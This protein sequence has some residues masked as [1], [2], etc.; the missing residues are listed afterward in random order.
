M[1]A[2]KCNIWGW[3]RYSCTLFRRILMKKCYFMKVLSFIL[4]LIKW[5]LYKDIRWMKYHF[6]WHL[7][8]EYCV[9]ISQTYP[10]LR[11]KGIIF[12]PC[13]FIYL[14]VCEFL[15]LTMCVSFRQNECET[16]SSEKQI[17]CIHL[18]KI[19]HACLHIITI[20]TK[21]EKKIETKPC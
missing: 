20:G 14:S 13:V 19:I 11:M 2:R 12:R 8:I 6:L 17:M 16:F 4:S 21:P 9:H 7:N 15:I 10:C 5:Y 1:L 3:E 18:L